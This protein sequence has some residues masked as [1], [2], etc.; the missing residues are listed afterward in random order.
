VHIRGEFREK[1]L[2]A[3]TITNP[4]Y[5]PHLR[6]GIRSIS[7]FYASLP[8]IF[9]YRDAQST[10]DNNVISIDIPALGLQ[11]ITE[12]TVIRALHSA[13]AAISGQKIVSLPT[14]ETAMLCGH[15]KNPSWYY[16]HDQ[17]HE[18]ASVVCTKC[19]AAVKITRSLHQPGH[20]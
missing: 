3:T 6:H 8:V 12:P 16:T 2:L 11:G 7:L 4:V 10:T 18:P 19:G 17:F 13:S 1:R 9:D 14:G 20:A 5:S 15:C